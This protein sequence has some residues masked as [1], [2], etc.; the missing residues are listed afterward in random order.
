MNLR[1]ARCKFS[2]LIVDLLTWADDQGMIYVLDEGMNHQNKGHMVGSLHYSGCAQDILLY[3]DKGNYLTDDESYRPLGEYWKS[4]H[5]YCRW[6][7]DFPGD[8]NHFSFSVPE[9]FGTKA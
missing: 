3:D 7:G 6:G 1:E 9:L 4:L 5:P 8:G 2:S